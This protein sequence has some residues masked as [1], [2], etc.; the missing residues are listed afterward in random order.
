MGYRRR[1]DW[2]EDFAA[3][4]PITR[5]DCRCYQSRQPCLYC[6]NHSSGPE[7]LSIQTPEIRAS[8]SEKSFLPRPTRK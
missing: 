5:V 6:K 8:A 7:C 3:D 1:K 4:W 2:M